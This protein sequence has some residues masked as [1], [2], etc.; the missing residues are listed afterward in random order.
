[1][2]YPQLKDTVLY[3]NIQ[4]PVVPFSL[5]NLS[6][7]SA[8]P[9][10]ITDDIIEYGETMIQQPTV[11]IESCSKSIEGI[12]WEKLPQ[13]TETRPNSGWSNVLSKVKYSLGGATVFSALFLTATR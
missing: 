13:L 2:N 12:D 10:E 5:E 7:P 8:P 3:P 4:S 1:M 11:K 6:K 9:S